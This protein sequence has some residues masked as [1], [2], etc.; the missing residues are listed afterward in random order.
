MNATYTCFSIQINL[1]NKISLIVH[2][3][4]PECSYKKN[5]Y[6]GYNNNDAPL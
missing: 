4:K 2:F 5:I 6:Q 3:M 1:F